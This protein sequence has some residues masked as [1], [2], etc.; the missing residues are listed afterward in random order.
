M[1]TTT[2]SL[3]TGSTCR[4]AAG[5]TLVEML[6]CAVITV[7]VCVLVA[8]MS[9]SMIGGI[10]SAS[11][12]VT[13]VQKLELIRT[14]LEN[15]LARIPRLADSVTR[16]TAI[17]D[18]ARWELALTFPA[19]SERLRTQGRAWEKVRYTWR[20]DQAILT[21]QY[22]LTDGRYSQPEVV[23]TGVITLDPQW[24][25]LTASTPVKG[26]SNWSRTSLPAFLRLHPHLTEVWEEGPLATLN[27]EA[28]HVRDFE[29]LIPVAGGE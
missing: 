20:K 18:E 6:V 9:T 24:L 22:D 13:A 26:E 4:A 29:T 25:I 8:E 23:A 1:K 19:R 17:G 11:G 12:R 14:T 2:E 10:S 3:N 7:L 15:D 21:R 28:S 5:F 27:A 16:L